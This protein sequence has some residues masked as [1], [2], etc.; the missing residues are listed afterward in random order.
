MRPASEKVLSDAVLAAGSPSS[1]CAINSVKMNATFSL[2]LVIF[3]HIYRPHPHGITVVSVPI[4]TVLPLTLSPFLWYYRNF[5]PHYRGYRGFTA[6]PIPMQLSSS[7]FQN[8][9]LA[10]SSVVTSLP[11]RHSATL[12]S[13]ATTLTLMTERDKLGVLTIFFLNNFTCNMVK[14]S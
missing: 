11:G 10:M 14:Y 1:D 5:R 13:F 8:W 4:T 6:V 7:E 12:V 2:T 3:C 9:K